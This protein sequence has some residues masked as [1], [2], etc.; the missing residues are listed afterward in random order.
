MDQLPLFTFVCEYAGGT[1]VSQAHAGSELDA[2]NWWIENLKKEK[3]IPGV[4]TVIAEQLRQS[5][6]GEQAVEFY[7]EPLHD[8]KNVWQFGDTF[9]DAQLYTTVVKTTA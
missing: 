3:F 8:L 4:S 6:E 1:Y 7:L 9:L 2:V 5:I